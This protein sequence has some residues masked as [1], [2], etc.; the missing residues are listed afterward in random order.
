MSFTEVLGESDLR[1]ILKRLNGRRYG[2]Y[3]RLRAKLLGY[4][5][6]EALLT[7]IQGDPYAPPSVIEITIPPNVHKL[8]NK[9]L[10]ERCIIPLLDYLARLLHLHSRRLR[11][12]CGT[13][14]SGYLGTPKPSPCILRRS[15]VDISGRSLVFRLFIGLPAKGRRI[16]GD[17]AR[18]ILLDKIPELVKAVI[19]QARVREDLEKHISLYLDQ[20]YIRRWLYESDA[21]AF[22]GDGSILPRESSYSIK[23]LKT[24]IPI[25]SPPELRARIKLPSGKTISGMILPRGFI[26]ITGGGYHGKT[27][28]LKAIQEGIYDHVKGDGREFVISRRRTILVKAEDGRLISHVD[29]SSFI[30]SLPGGVDTGDFSSSCASGSTSMAAAINEAIE[31]GAESI[32]IDEDTSATNLLYKDEVM[33]R[34]IREEP[35]KPLCMQGRSIIS[36]CGIGII[37]VAGA[38]S[39][40]ISAADRI[41][42]MENYLPREITE[43]ARR[44]APETSMIEYKPPR[45]RVFY[46]IRGLKKI[47]VSGFKLIARYENG[48]S[49]EL[50]VS[51]NPR[52]V[53]KGQ[54]NFIAHVLMS[55]R[56]PS[57][58]MYV[59]ELIEWINS[60]IKDKGFE[61]F[62]KPVPPDLA[63]VDGIDVI[64]VLNRLRNASFSQ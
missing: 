47:R 58:P 18:E 53:E 51:N 41:I 44:Y 12:K 24:A 20:E 8:P 19:F 29:I 54:V 32:L 56:K 26:T 60:A 6:G 52:I 4:E 13:G 31:A 34:I 35:I 1:E 40:L 23:P 30:E 49:F 59:R 61:A 7:R 28:L 62:V 16:L 55:L 27:T 15:C 17:K 48:E 2:A 42:I 25:K 5:F 50:D 10:D 46:G 39:S 63:L 38:S 45:K 21:L 14:N 22:I 43:Q 3:K 9:F 64:W 57:E 36:K 11:R 33:N 37:A